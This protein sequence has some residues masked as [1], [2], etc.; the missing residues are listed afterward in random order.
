MVVWTVD[1]DLRF[2]ASSGGGLEH[3][4]LRG[5][6][7]KGRTLAEYFGSDDPDFLPIAM[8]RRAAAGETVRFDFTWQDRHFE[9]H[10]EPLQA[11]GENGGGGVA[12]VIGL[13]VDVTDRRR[14]EQALRE[15]EERY[16]ALFEQSK[17][18]IYITSRDGR[19]LEMNPAGLELFGYDIEQMRSL[20]V[21][22]LYVDPV[23][24]RR[25]QR[26]IEERGWVQDFETQLR[27]RG[28]E[29]I[30]ALLTT[31][32]RSG[33]DG[34]VLGYQGIIRDVTDRK[35]FE[36]QLRRRA[37]HD[38][39]TEL[40][41]RLLFDDRIATAVARA[42]RESR[43]MAVL[44]V[45][46]DRFKVVNDGLGHAAGD[47]VLLEVGRRIR[48]ALRREDTVAR[49]GG[50]EFTVLLEELG[51]RQEA[52]DVVER[53]LEALDRPFRVAGQEFRLS[54]SVGVAIGPVPDA[55]PGE[56][57][58]RA[59]VAMYRAKEQGGTAYHVFDPDTDLEQTRRFER[60]GELRRALEKDELTLFY[61][62]IVSLPS[63]RIV[64]VE[65][66]ARWLHPGRGLVMPTEFIPLAEETG[67]IVPLG[68]RLLERA[69]ADLRAWDAAVERRLSLHVNL[70]SPQLDEPGLL[71]ALAD[72]LEEAEIDADRL[73]FEVT[74]RL[75]MERPERIEGLKSLGV[76]VS[77]DDFGTGYSSLSYLKRLRA[78]S[79]KI[80]RSFVHGLAQ[81][82]RDDAIVRT[83]LTLGET[84]EL[85]VIAEGVE[86]EA[87]LERLRELGCELAQGFYFA[88]PVPAAE[89]LELWRRDPSW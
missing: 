31:T 88:R 12:G 45:D 2:T 32:V 21:H 16:R 1:R 8:H 14:M 11:R 71:P 42:R 72:V 55:G 26:A 28:E 79:L 66:L 81:D 77:V 58:R 5:D 10:L 50:D 68:H 67:L 38:P 33:P 36:E 84:L 15:S 37:L 70:S 4:G 78:D 56:L 30:D 39:L 13:A 49:F 46:L 83:I 51:S 44:F 89:L 47:R 62:P 7:V 3:L 53:L 25:F 17:D 64:G 41:N 65:P 19:V 57:V 48:S 60:E 86:T 61:Q 40:P 85:T 75:A 23:D 22:A 52:I 54:A 63:G 6:E 43:P 18:A 82:P 87:Q 76:R 29:L 69:C 80:D 9:V 34:E 20:D 24:R 35:R 73:H 74:E 59:D 27:T